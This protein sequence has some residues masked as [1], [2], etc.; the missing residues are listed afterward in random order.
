MFLGGYDMSPI[1]P[2]IGPHY[3]KE[4]NNNDTIELEIYKI[5]D[6]VADNTRNLSTKPA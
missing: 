2:P 3:D 6:F 1:G 4:N 5:A